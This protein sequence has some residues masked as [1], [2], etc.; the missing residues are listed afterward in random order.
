MDVTTRPCLKAQNG[1]MMNVKVKHDPRCDAWG[2]ER[3]YLD[4]VCLICKLIKT[5]ADAE[6]RRAA[7]DVEAL[8]YLDHGRT[9]NRNDAIIAARRGLRR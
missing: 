4:G 6:A 5:T 3:T 9:V 2:F 7:D 8:P 1:V